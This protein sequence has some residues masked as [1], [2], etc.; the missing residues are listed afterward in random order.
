MDA[1]ELTKSSAWRPSTEDDDL[2]EF[3]RAV[4]H[5]PPRSEAAIGSRWGPAGRYVVESRL[6]RGGMGIVYVANDTLLRRLV[7]L[8]VLD[9]SDAPDVAHR[10]RLL[11]EARLA[12]RVEHERVARVYDVGE[13]DG[14]LF[15]AM[16]LVRGMTLRKWM[17]EHHADPRVLLP[18]VTSI[19]E[20]LAALHACGVIH[21]DLKPDNVMVLADGAIKLLDFGLARPTT[22]LLDTESV[23]ADARD[24]SC[25]ASVAAFSGTPAY[26]S[27][28]QWRG[29][30]LDARVDVFALGIVIYELVSG[31]RP[32]G[33][34]AHMDMLEAMQQPPSFADA[35]WSAMPPGLSPIVGRALSHAA[36][37]RFADG[38]EVLVALRTLGPIADPPRTRRVRR[39][40]VFALALVAVA[41]VALIF[42]R[43]ADR[44]AHE[45]RLPAGMV[46]IAGGV[47]PLGRTPGEIER[48]C[49]EI[50]P[51]CGRQQ[52]QREVPRGSEQVVPFFLDAREVTNTEYAEFLSTLGGLLFVVDDEDDHSPRF[53]RLNA[54]VGSGQVLLDLHAENGGIEHVADVDGRVYR[55]RAGR[56]QLPVAQVTW[57]G[58][59]LYCETRG[60]R[61]PTEDEWEGAAR[62][63]E[64]RR[65][66]WGDANVRCGDVAVPNDGLIPLPASCPEQIAVRI[67]GA[68]AQ[69]VT[70]E[71]VYDLAGNVAEWTSSIF[72]EGDRMARP[73]S[74]ASDGP[75]VIR[76]GSWGESIM[77]RASGRSRRPPIVAGP[78]LGFRCAAN[79]TTKQ[80]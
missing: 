68:S 30:S 69:D 76:G 49:V 4:A 1:S 67:G 44:V 42:L 70:R 74:D 75:R 38:S 22:R 64:D 46:R 6:G 41:G 36:A 65:Y 79:A 32:F 37:D 51:T 8:K 12:A 66:P 53:V 62:G 13:H 71:G 23:D 33:D 57:Y 2:S 54:G 28:E 80:E 47:V 48:E 34:R 15:V 58:A 24:G 7:A 14:F 60:K 11:R 21:R 3:L 59:T 78:N 29:G 39:K 26:M 43:R 40:A 5:A 17:A 52:M 45:R 35:S 31:K 56:E 77:A 61:L 25:A 18:V 55:A 27:P 72:V 20:G 19:A 73:E 9:S 63:P 10:E 16:E 50:G